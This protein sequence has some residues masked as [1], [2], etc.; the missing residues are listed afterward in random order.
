MLCGDLPLVGSGASPIR[1][2]GAGGGL[3]SAEID[4]RHV[5]LLPPELVSLPPSP[6]YGR[7]P[8]ARLPA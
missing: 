6:L 8:D 1:A 7:A 4:A 5:T 3:L 2:A